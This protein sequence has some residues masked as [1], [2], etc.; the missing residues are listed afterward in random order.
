MVNDMKT[1][2]IILGTIITLSYS[3]SFGMKTNKVEDKKDFTLRIM[4]ARSEQNQL[5]K[6]FQAEVGAHKET[7]PE[8]AEVI[9]F[10]NSEIRW[11]APTK[12]ADNK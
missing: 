6:S 10:L 4:D 8:E 12:N 7:T 3:F 2:N 1:K 5:L 9:E 11:K